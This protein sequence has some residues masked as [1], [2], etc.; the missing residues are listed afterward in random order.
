MTGNQTVGCV[1]SAP[2]V[3]MTDAVYVTSGCFSMAAIKKDGTLWTWGNNSFGSCGVDSG[4]IDFIEEPVKAAEN[5]KMVWIDQMLNNSYVTRLMHDVRGQ[6]RYTENTFIEKKDGT[7]WACG[8][9]VTGVGRQG[10]TYQLSGDLL[11]PTMRYF[12]N[13][14]N[15]ITISEMNHHPNELLAECEF[16]WTKEE[17]L[18]YLDSIGMDHDEMNIADED[19]S[20]RQHYFWGYDYC[21]AFIMNEYEQL[22]QIQSFFV[23]SRDGKLWLGMSR[24]EAEEVLGESYGEKEYPENNNYK[25]FYYKAESGYYTLCFFKG[26]LE[27]IDESLYSPEE[28]MTTKIDVKNPL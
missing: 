10:K 9:D 13:V 4:D 3:M 26:E 27:R 23:G 12:T 20:N 7:L 6:C 15:P 21:Y 25:E 14:F 8:A 11:E 18:A 24:E 5:V 2:H 16:G 22:A 17:L 28:Y 1:F 19:G